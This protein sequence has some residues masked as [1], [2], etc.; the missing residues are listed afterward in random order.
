[1]IVYVQDEKL[2]VPLWVIDHSSFLEWIRSGNVPDSLRVG[3]IHD[4][5]WIDTMSERAFAH[6]QLKAWITAVLLHLINDDS[7]G[8]FFT[9]GM[10]FTSETERFSTVPDGMF[11]SQ[12]TIDH[13]L[14]RLSG[15]RDGHEDTEVLGTPDLMIEV[16]SDNSEEKDTEWLVSKYW[17]AGIREYWVVDG[18]TNPLR[19]TIY[20]WRSR[21]YV[22]VRKQAGWLLSAVFGRSFRFVPGPE[23]LGFKTYRFEVK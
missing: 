3:Y 9:D 21:G 23:Q 1:M 8:V 12:S 15:G 17:A 18:R 6:N 5:V 20:R 19:F 14:I 13:G 2:E 16:V 7:Q 22:S 11:A 4:H 10:L